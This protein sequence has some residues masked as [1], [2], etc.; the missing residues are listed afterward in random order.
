[1]PVILPQD[2]IDAWLDP[3]CKDAV[4]LLQPYPADAMA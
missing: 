2:S 4:R 1:M 3:K